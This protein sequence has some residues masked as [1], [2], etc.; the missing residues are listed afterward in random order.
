MNTWTDIKAAFDDIT[1]DSS[2]IMFSAESVARWANNAL[3]DLCDAGRYIDSEIIADAPSSGVVVSTS[4]VGYDVWRVEY[5]DEALYPITR[6]ALRSGDRDWNYRVGRPRFYYLDQTNTS[7]DYLFVGIWEKPATNE[8]NA[9]R[10]WVHGYPAAP[11]DASPSTEIDVPDW[12]VSAVLFYML[13]RA[14]E[15]DTK[16]QSFDVAGLYQMMYEDIKERLVIR[17]KGRDQKKWVVGE[18][19]RP[20]INVLNRLPDRIPAP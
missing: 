18:S 7:P 6:D 17:S 19:G 8:T 9:M 4:A 14:Y 2:R 12:A 5:D 16:I 3:Q 13:V 15:A 11:S 10:L 1:R 20:S